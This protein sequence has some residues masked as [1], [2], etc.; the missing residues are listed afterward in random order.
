MNK[1]SLTEIQK[2]Y[3]S[4]EKLT[5]HL[6][7][8][9]THVYLEVEGKNISP[10]LLREAWMEVLNIH[11]VLRACI[12]N[13]QELSFFKSS[14]NNYVP[15]FDLSKMKNEDAEIELLKIRKAISNRKM[16]I[17]YGHTCGLFLSV[18]PQKICRLHFDLNLIVC[19]VVGF[20]ILLRDLAKAYEGK[21]PH[22]T[23]Y[24]RVKMRTYTEDDRSYWINRIPH[25]SLGPKLDLNKN[26]R[27]MYNCEYRPLEH[28]LTKYKWNFFKKMAM[29]KGIAPHLAI[30]G[31]FAFTIHHF[32]ENDSFILNVPVVDR[33][34]KDLDYLADDTQILLLESRYNKNDIF[35]KFLLQLVEQYTRDLKHLN[36]SGL[37][38]QTLLKKER[39][40]AQW[41]AP[42]VFSSTPQIKL[43]SDDFCRVFGKLIYMVSQTPQVWLDAQIHEIEDE[44]YSFWI[45]PEGLFPDLYMSGMFN[46]YTELL[47]ALASDE[48]AW[49]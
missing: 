27:K 3:I 12:K 42:V 45:V 47:D 6:G 11:P 21:M 28:V 1:L 35:F 16:Q 7:G 36:F 44:I 18:C 19:D 13:Q 43:L 24:P 8:V 30:L 22:G 34:S 29:S 20:Q 48:T 32:C 33:D 39:P 2:A 31:A 15:V 38:V 9:G 49:N 25:L 17:E 41:P 23:I 5:S 46:E 26:P 14:Y 37:E 4:G 40:A 10:E